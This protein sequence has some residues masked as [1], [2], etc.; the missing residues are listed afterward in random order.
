MVLRAFAA[1]PRQR[2]TPVARHAAALLKSRFFKA[3]AYADRRGPEYWTK[4]TFPFQYTNLLTALDSLSKMGF[5]ADDPDV[6]R[7]IG[8][9]RDQQRSD[10]SFELTRCRGIGDKRLPYWLGIAL[11]RALVRLAGAR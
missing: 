8:W 1:H 6:A 3:D 2:R 5:S 11:A 7:A 4:F 9:F 10:G